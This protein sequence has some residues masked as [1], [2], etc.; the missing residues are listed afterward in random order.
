MPQFLK[1]DS[2]EQVNP[3]QTWMDPKS[4]VRY[5]PASRLYVARLVHRSEDDELAAAEVLNMFPT[6]HAV[7]ETYTPL[8]CADILQ[9]MQFL[10]EN[11]PIFTLIKYTLMYE[12]VHPLWVQPDHYPLPSAKCP[13]YPSSLL[14]F[15]AH[16]NHFR[17]VWMAN[18]FFKG[19][20]AEDNPCLLHLFS[21]L[22]WSGALDHDLTGTLLA[23]PYGSKWFVLLILRAEI[24]FRKLKAGESPAMREWTMPDMDQ[25][26]RNI[27]LD[28]M[29][30]TTRFL[31]SH[32][33]M[34]TLHAC[35]LNPRLPDTQAQYS[36][37]HLHNPPPII[38]KSRCADVCWQVQ[39]DDLQPILHSSTSAPTAVSKKKLP[40]KSEVVIPV[41]GKGKARA[42]AEPGSDPPKS[43][44][45][46]AASP[47]S[48]EVMPAAHGPD[49]SMEDATLLGKSVNVE[50]VIDIE[51]E[52]DQDHNP[53]QAGAKTPSWADTD[54]ESAAHDDY[55]LDEP[56]RAVASSSQL[57]SERSFCPVFPRN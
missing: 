9:L 52:D 14:T 17:S 4:T 35:S 42:G 19:K 8:E 38:A 53:T 11:A 39:Q 13:N 26:R 49:V 32:I 10:P 7:E 30:L 47:E 48:E 29:Y 55:D 20:H 15:Y 22:L 36:L 25:W 34:T 46:Q 27:N 24:T 1:V 54:M 37:A 56:P 3:L 44:N 57:G 2:G 51:D 31:D 6:A 41:T 28:M 23:G 12:R 5:G 45:L 40:K 16:L 18:S 43:Q 33:F 21:K 50:E